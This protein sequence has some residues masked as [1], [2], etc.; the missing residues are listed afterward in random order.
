MRSRA[1]LTIESQQHKGITFNSLKNGVYSLGS[2]P[3]NRF[4]LK[5]VFIKLRYRS[6]LIEMKLKITK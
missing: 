3:V 1:S 6:H 4:V 5:L 2:I